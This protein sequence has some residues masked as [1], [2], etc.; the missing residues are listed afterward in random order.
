MA[1]VGAKEDCTFP[2]DPTL[3][4]WLDTGNPTLEKAKWKGSCRGELHDVVS[5]YNWFVKH[6]HTVPLWP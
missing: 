6:E 1:K 5:P 3:F 2:L 4:L